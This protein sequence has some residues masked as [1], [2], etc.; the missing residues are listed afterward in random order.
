MYEEPPEQETLYEEPPMVGSLHLGQGRE[1]L[2]PET[3]SPATPGRLTTLNLEP[4]V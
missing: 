2:G 3:A 1:D 4:L